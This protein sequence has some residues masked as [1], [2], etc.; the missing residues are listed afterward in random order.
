[1]YLHILQ[2][3][4]LVRVH[5]QPA[6][7]KIGIDGSVSALGVAWQSDGVDAGYIWYDRVE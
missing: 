4:N 6:Q 5:S 1:M 3:P 7:F 2:A